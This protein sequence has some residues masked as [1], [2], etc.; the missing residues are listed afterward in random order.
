MKR[1][2]TG[3]QPSLPVLWP[4]TGAGRRA[5]RY[6]SH[7]GWRV[8]LA[9]VLTEWRRVQIIGQHGSMIDAPH[10]VLWVRNWL[11]P[12]MDHDRS[13]RK[14][15]LAA[16]VFLPKLNGPAPR[17]EWWCSGLSMG[18]LYGYA[19]QLGEAG[20]QE[21]KDAADRAL[22]TIFHLEEAEA[23]AES[24]SAALDRALGL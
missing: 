17:M 20:E 14:Q 15:V 9:P 11:H 5:Q 3:F 23:A 1:I 2:E 22:F 7:Q 10:G 4:C 12:Q 18:T 13:E 16:R 24:A 6:E 21:S 19:K 8:A